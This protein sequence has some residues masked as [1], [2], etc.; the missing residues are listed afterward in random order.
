MSCARRFDVVRMLT[1]VGV[2]FF[3]MVRNVWASMV[4]VVGPLAPIWGVSVP[5]S[6]RGERSRR[7]ASTMPTARDATAMSTA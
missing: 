2:T 4:P 5:A 6:E 7:D 1:T 3:A